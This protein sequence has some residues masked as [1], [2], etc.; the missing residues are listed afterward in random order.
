MIAVAT[1][2]PSMPSNDFTVA[3]FSQKAKSEGWSFWRGVVIGFCTAF[4]LAYM[5]FGGDNIFFALF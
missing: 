1:S 5:A 4:P 2:S 3:E